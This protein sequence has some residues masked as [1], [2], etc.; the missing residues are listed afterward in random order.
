MPT[1]RRL[2]IS[3][4]L[5]EESDYFSPAEIEHVEYE[6][7][8]CI[9]GAGPAGLSAAIWLKQLEREKRNEIRVMVLRRDPKC[10]HRLRRS[11]QAAHPRWAL[12][13]LASSTPKPPT[14]PT[15]DAQQNALPHKVALH[16]HAAPPI[17]G[18]YRKLHHLPLAIH[19]LVGRDSG[20]RIR[21]GDIPQF[22]WNPASL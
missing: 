11:N 7:D 2:H 19:T 5:Q 21:H 17:N 18:Q 8:V 4:P 16:T 22:R 9:I 1:P 20:G 3:H 6:A 12:A 14:H 15:R 10:T 13:I